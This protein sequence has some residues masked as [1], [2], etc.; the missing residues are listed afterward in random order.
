MS[1]RQTCRNVGAAIDPLFFSSIVLL[2]DELRI[3]TGRGFLEALATGETGWSR[4]A[5]RLHIKSAKKRTGAGV[6]RSE[7]MMQVLL[8]STLGAL[9]N[10]RTVMYES[11]LIT[12][13]EVLIVC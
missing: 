12:V 7:T 11:L 4:Y 8:A 10:I 6:H 9:S 5:Q 3:D 13:H 1:L 2:K